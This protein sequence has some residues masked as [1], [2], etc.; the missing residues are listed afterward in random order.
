MSSRELARLTLSHLL[1]LL[2]VLHHVYGPSVVSVEVLCTL[3]KE[4]YMVGW[5]WQCRCL[6]GLV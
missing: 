4:K 5:L 2:V 6:L 3:T 1:Q